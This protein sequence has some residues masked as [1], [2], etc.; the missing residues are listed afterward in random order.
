MA[1]KQLAVQEPVQPVMMNGSSSIASYAVV[2][3]NGNVGL[4]LKPEAI[5]SG[6]RVGG[7][8][9][10]TYIAATI[11]SADVTQL[12]KEKDAE[13]G[14]VVQMP[15]KMSLAEAWPSVK[16]KKQDASRCSTTIGVFLDVDLRKEPEKVLKEFDS[17]K[18]VNDMADYVLGLVPE[19]AKKLL[20]K[21][22]LSAWIYEQYV[23]NLK[24]VAQAAEAYKQAVEDNSK[25]IG[26]FGMQVDQLKAM[27]GKSGHSQDAHVEDADDGE[28]GAD[29]SIEDLDDHDHD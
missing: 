27:Y 1:K 14:K 22:E 4:G 7:P 6:S 23:P 15:K 17:R 3:R 18:V 25:N 9:N 13:I 24:K 5:V 29:E 12:F 11:R 26:V 8:A 16:W 19:G 28:V 10:T 2:A 20:R 21:Q